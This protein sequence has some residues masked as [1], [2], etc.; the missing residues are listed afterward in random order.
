M[1]RPS[2][3]ARGLPRR[4]TRITGLLL[5]MADRLFEHGRDVEADFDRL[6]VGLAPDDEV[7]AALAVRRSA[8]RLAH[9]RPTAVRL[10]QPVILRLHQ[11]LALR[12]ERLDRVLARQASSAGERRLLRVRRAHDAR[13]QPCR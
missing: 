5:D 12:G 6:A 11:R 7:V 8:E 13:N 3:L 9:E 4:T 1:R 10:A 2:P